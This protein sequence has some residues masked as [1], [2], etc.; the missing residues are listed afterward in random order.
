MF[1]KGYGQHCP[2]MQVPSSPAE[3]EGCVRNVRGEAECQPSLQGGN[4]TV[5]DAGTQGCWDAGGP[6]KEH[7][8]KACLVKCVCGPK[9][10]LWNSHRESWGGGVPV[11]RIPGR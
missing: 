5:W 1:G 2:G 6:M 9:L 8:G 3:G 4:Q 10:E 11:T 7:G